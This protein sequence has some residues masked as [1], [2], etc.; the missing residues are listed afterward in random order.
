[1][2]RA[3]KAI[4]ILDALAKWST[5]TF[6]VE[7]SNFLIDSLTARSV[8]NGPGQRWVRLDAGFLNGGNGMTPLL[9]LRAGSR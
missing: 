8:A 1:M 6:S 2:T 4:P 3:K 5:E 7:K 9:L